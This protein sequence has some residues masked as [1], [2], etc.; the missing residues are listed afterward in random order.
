MSPAAPGSPGQ[1]A[2]LHYRPDID[3]LRAIAVLAVVWFHSGLPGLPGGFAGVDV[4]FVISGYLITGIIQRELAA[5]TFSFARFYE[6]RFR[7]I[8]PALVVV[9]AA[10]LVAGY[11]LL[12]P[13][14]LVR[15]GRSGVAALGMVPNF[16]YLMNGGGYFDFGKRIA[17]PLLHTW[18]L[19]VE[20]QFYLLFP[21]FLLLATRW[22]VVRPAI[23]AVA[24]VSFASCVVATTYAPRAAFYMLPSRAWELALGAAPAVGLL[25]IP[26][27][28]RPAAA[29][30]GLAMVIG[31]LMLFDNGGPTSF[32]LFVIPALGTALTI[33]AGPTTLVSR[34]LA[35]QPLTGIGWISYSLY[36]WHWPVFALTGHWRA[37]VKLP[38]PVAFGCIAVTAAL[39]WLTWRWIEQPAR[40]RSIPFR[41]I[42]IATILGASI[43][44]A[45]SLAAIRERGFAGRFPSE[46]L[47]RLAQRDDYTPLA[48]ICEGAD[49]A[50]LERKCL[51]GHGPPTALVWG[52]S[53]AAADSAGI[54]A[55]LGQPTLIATASACVPVLSAPPFVEKSCANHNR[56][57][58]D[59]LRKH[60]EIATVVMVAHWSSYQKT[61]AEKAQLWPGVRAAMV[62]LPGRRKILLVGT[63][64]PGVD[65]PW[66]GAIRERWGRPPPSWPCPPAKVP[67]SGAIVVDLSAAFCAYPQPWRLFSDGN[68]PSLTANREVIAPA[69]RAALDKASS[70]SQ[71]SP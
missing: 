3:G 23:V 57:V 46:A 18:S 15:L 59:W 71:P 44:L 70:L 60:P 58:L 40:R 22:R 24:L 53:H 14:D 6:R 51:I 49:I 12:V 10:T 28:L 68:H 35:L 65:V 8:A 21:M 66:A 32:W 9:L 34:L 29:T 56:A 38:L 45:G 54:A 25:S 41:S 33:A 4:F 13:G 67:I 7:R 48:V 1:S 11:V 43:V 30:T 36:L 42:A 27:Q 19:G 2:A 37:A 69:L 63:P 16:Y 50:Q 47:A 52:D 20:E 64:D 31:G 17:P 26:R 55:G 5:G 61:P 62:A 39:A